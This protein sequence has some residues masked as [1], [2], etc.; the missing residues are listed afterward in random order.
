M[1][2]PE[3]HRVKRVSFGRASYTIIVVF[4][5][6]FANAMQAGK[7]FALFLPTASQIALAVQLL[8]AALY[9][10]VA[11]RRGH[12]AI[13]AATVG[14][15]AYLAAAHV[16]F[17]ANSGSKYNFDTIL[18]Y[19]P[20]LSFVAFYEFNCSIR[21]II[22]IY[23]VIA[24]L[25]VAFYIVLNS[26]VLSG[27]IGRGSII[28]DSHNEDSS[29][30]YF[31][32]IYGAF[33]AFYALRAQQ[34]HASLRMVLLLMVVYAF[35]LSGTRALF[36]IMSIVFVI[37]VIQQMNF[38]VRMGLL[39]VTLVL[40]GAMLV[41]LFFP[42]WN[43]LLFFSTDSS[44]YYRAR[45]Y[46]TAIGTIRAHWFLGVGTPS[47]FQALQT[48]LGTPRYEPLY[49]SDLGPIAAFFEFGIIGLVAYLAAVIFCLTV[50]LGN[51]DAE[52]Q[53]LQ[54]T[55]ITCALYAVFSPLILLEAGAMFVMLLIAAWLRER[56]PVVRPR[57]RPVL[58]EALADR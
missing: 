36:F 45:E 19:V 35:W 26:V 57:V 54:L 56:R 44:A 51:H 10:L 9:M 31:A 58:T 8:I 50:E 48:F 15:I 39:A 3:L 25:Y 52:Q 20:L 16:I 22:R 13:I 11:I 33:L 41:G 43:P 7:I 21:R 2:T 28:L 14:L 55:C 53:A 47:D 49:A 6:L 4:C 32:G 27:N 46:Y 17:V 40:M 38:T 30:V 12:G 34:L 5:L 18:T 29:R 24:A 42:S 23:V 1:L 37:A